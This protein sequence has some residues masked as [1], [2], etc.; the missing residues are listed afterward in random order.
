MKMRANQNFWQVLN[1]DYG[2]GWVPCLVCTNCTT[3]PGLPN[4]APDAFSA[5]NS[6]QGNKHDSLLSV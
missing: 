1:A 6:G 4:T 5:S 3:R 2:A